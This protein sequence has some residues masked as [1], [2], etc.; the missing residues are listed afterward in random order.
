MLNKELFVLNP[1]E[2][3]LKNDGVVEI[4][5]SKT[6]VK[7]LQIT[8][9][10]IK[11]FVC[12]GEY[13]RG[14]YRIL[15]TYLK[16]FDQPKQPAVWV[17]GFFGSGKSHLVK[18]LSYFWEDFAFSDGMTARM[19]KPLPQEVNDLFV[20]IKR[21]QDLHG[22]VVIRGLFS[23]FPS[24]DLRYSFLQLFLH[25][26]GLPNKLHQFKFYYWCQTEGILYGLKAKLQQSNRNFNEE[27][28]NLYVSKYISN[29]I[30]ELMPGYAETEAQVRDQIGRNFPRVEVISREDFLY[31][32]KS[33]VLKLFHPH[34]PCILVALDEVQQFIGSDQDRSHQVQLLSEDLCENFDGKLLLVGTGQNALSDTPMLQKMADRF[35]VNVPLSDKDVETVTR[36]TV[37]E[38][39]PT[40][41]APITGK[42]E[43]SI[44]E[45]SRLLEGTDYG[46]TQ[47]DKQILVADYP[48]LPS[49]RKFWKKVLQAIDVAGTSGQ[50]RSQL[51]IVD[52]SIKSVANKSL[53]EVIAADFIFKQKKQQLIQNA[54]LLNEQSNMIEELAA[55]GED[56]KLKARIL[57]IVFLIDLLPKE[58]T[59][60][61]LRSDKKTIADLMIDNL[62]VATDIFRNRIGLLIEELANK[63]KYLI[64][65]EDEFRLQTR[66]GSEWEQEFTNQA[67]KIRNDDAK[68]YE[69]RR[70]KILAALK[71]KLSSTYFQQGKS[72]IRRDFLL[73]S[74]DTRPPVTDKLNLW[75]RDG[76]I[77][78]ENTLLDEIRAEGT[79]EPLGYLY[80]SKVKDQEVKREI[81][82]FLA[83]NETIDKKG[84]PATPEGLMVKKSMDTRK[85]MAGIEVDKIVE[86]ICNQ[87]KVYLAGGALIDEADLEGN[88]K[89]ALESITIR[90]FPKFRLADYED[91]DKAL[92]RVL[93]GD[94]QALQALKFNSE[95]K[96]HPMAT[97]MT[98]FIGHSGKSGKD[99]RN[100]FNSEPYGWSQDAIDTMLVILKLTGHLSTPEPNLNQ[101]TIAQAYFKVEALTLSTAQKVQIR[102]LYQ[103]AG[104]N[105][106]PGDELKCSLEF[107]QK[108]NKL[109]D[110]IYGDAPM[111]E[112][113]DTRLIVDLQNLD[114]NERLLGII[115]NAD[116]LRLDYEHWKRDADTIERRIP[117]WRLLVSLSRFV[118]EGEEAKGIKEEI[119]AIRNE[120]L[121][122][123]EP[124][125]I[126]S[127][128]NRLT[129]YLRNELNRLKN[130]YNA[131][132][133]ERM[134]LLQ[135]NEY[136]IKLSPEQK[137]DVLVRQQ[138]LAKPE[139]RTYDANELFA[140]LT[141]ISLDAWKDKVEALPSK[142]Q[143]AVDQAIEISAPKAKY[144]TLP[145]TTIHNEAELN[146]YLDDLKH[147]IKDM[148]SE[149]DVILK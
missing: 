11:T 87:A 49:T 63:D 5:T 37:L 16:N 121:I 136:F 22:S 51:R 14:L 83:A 42:I 116:Q 118:L 85:K 47:D 52:E 141:K 78:N 68:L 74:G 146:A 96:E 110:S 131:I 32:I 128:L 70:S 145:K 134:P 139:I 140:Q 126:Q 29:A 113:V 111:P 1:D 50:L 56:G 101:K 69:Q 54:L 147:E 124:D 61:K 57:A 12:E 102:K 21:K 98:A 3:N 2:N 15:D 122:L 127:P 129:E 58:T 105:C 103:E 34:M 125:P 30:M 25:N 132:Y 88:V 123:A 89:K 94:T 64:P 135:S 4:N 23:D 24:K 81:I 39:K 71:G 117:E 35:T 8:R 79:D 9:H 104:A 84:T 90:Q 115:D 40:A 148:L 53:G 48:I 95:P 80:L 107:L 149:G 77:E 36:K 92:K 27:L 26:L 114:G 33:Q 108:L 143:G 109:A 6:D 142:F 82:K 66:I 75:I 17:S 44:G 97:D 73:Y 72:K 119:N 60:F 19:V 10:E 28:N 45:I 76:W 91:W 43:S 93:I 41:H 7:G 99:I 38:K 20:E 13:E 130:E 100:H 144:F 46:F 67:S 133:D 31:V 55:K 137:H 59:K 106:K 120:R 62:N 138:L 86:E 65:V 18:L 112:F